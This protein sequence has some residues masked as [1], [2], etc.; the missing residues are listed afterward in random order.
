M[1]AEAGGVVLIAVLAR[2]WIALVILFRMKLVEDFIEVVVAKLL[3]VAASLYS[4]Q[5]SLLLLVPTM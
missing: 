5:S 3:V 2:R 4:I 1:D